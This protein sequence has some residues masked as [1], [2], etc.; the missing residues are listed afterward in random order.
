LFPTLEGFNYVVACAEIN[1]KEILM[2]ATE[3]K[4]TLG[5]LPSRAINWEGTL[6]LSNGSSRKIRLFPE[7]A[8]R[9]DVMMSVALDK[10]GNVKGKRRASMTDLDAFSFRNS[11]KDSRIEAIKNDQ[12]AMEVSDY[13]T[14]NGDD[15][16]KPII[17]SFA[18]ELEDVVDIVGDEIYF[19]PLLDLALDENPFKSDDRIYPVDFV[20]PVSRKKM[21][22]I[23][24]PE[25]YAVASF[26][27]PIKLSLPNNM[28]SFLFNV[29]ETPMGLN[30]VSD[31]K[32][33]T[34]IIPTPYYSELKEFYNQRV[35]KETEKVVL[36]K[37]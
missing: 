33:N 28:G 21:I 29:K 27:K 15:I 7:T 1:G 6:V 2:D 25:G 9:S 3:K 30:L 12:N 8:S 14:K 5:L 10:E 37:I 32:M 11:S 13:K 20:H 24:I 22:T 34:S 31:F 18:F 17:E 35:I 36:K 23:T 4:L 19:S 26:P 16:N